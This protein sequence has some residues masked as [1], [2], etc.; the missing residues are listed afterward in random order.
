MVGGTQR[1]GAERIFQED[2]WSVG[3][4]RCLYINY[5]YIYLYFFKCESTWCVVR[6]SMLPL[7]TFNCRDSCL[8]PF[9]ML[10]HSMVIQS[11]P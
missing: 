2:L 4:S 11:F 1:G 6:A 5:I 10:G 3:R 9:L 7:L 8:F